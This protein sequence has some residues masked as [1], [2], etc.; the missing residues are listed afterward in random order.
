MS[1][2]LVE[3]LTKTFRVSR[4]APGLL[5]SIKGLLRRD[6]RQIRALDGISFSIRR[7]ELVGYVGPNGSESRRR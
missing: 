7:G 5:G 3:N 4:R 2:I 6:V 1:Q